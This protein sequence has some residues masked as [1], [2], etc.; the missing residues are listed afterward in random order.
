MK[1]LN[2]EDYRVLIYLHEAHKEEDAGY[3]KAHYHNL[4]RLNRFGFLTVV[5]NQKR[6]P[7]LVIF[8]KRVNDLFRNRHRQ[9]HEH[10]KIILEYN[11]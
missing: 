8:T 2:S 10:E 1:R 5:Y 7:Y 11:I 9:R 3:L 4:R 6:L